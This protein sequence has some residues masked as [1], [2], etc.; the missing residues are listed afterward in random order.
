MFYQSSPVPVLSYAEVVA[1]LRMQKEVLERAF[2]G[3]SVLYKVQTVI[4]PYKG[5]LQINLQLWIFQDQTK[6]YGFFLT[7][8]LKPSPS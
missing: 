8:T 7:Q 6:V 2:F 4:P 1:S 5:W 3:L